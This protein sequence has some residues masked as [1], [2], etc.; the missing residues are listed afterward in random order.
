MPAL[1]LTATRFLISGSLM[2][3]FCRFRGL[4]IFYGRREMAW[5]ALL[6]F[7]MLG[8]SNCALVWSEKVLA[9]GLAALLVAVVPLYVALLERLLPGGENLHP[10][11][12]LGLLLGF[13]GLAALMWPS[14]R[15]GIH[16]QTT[17]ALA[18]AVLLVGSLS[19]AVGSLLSRRARLP[20]NVVVAAAWQMLFAGL[21]NGVL[22]TLQ[23]SWS[24]VQWTRPAALSI[25]YLVT[26]GSWVGYTAYIWLLHHVP[27]GK[28]ATFAYVNPL[29]AV[30]LRLCT[31]GRAAGSD[32]ISG[33]GR[34]NRRGRAG[35][36]LESGSAGRREPRG[37][38][39]R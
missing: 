25:A 37:R 19:W 32:R 22:A 13:A 39:W 35:H 36:F 8:L 18:G 10:K 16:G 27:V 3:A 31:A 28:V 26:F 12:L 14:L 11:G 9:S 20:V 4:R 29:V 23:G 24:S 34:G 7:L 1:A 5:L 15:H 6:G 30:I 33:N 38:R 21:I 17:Q 2:L